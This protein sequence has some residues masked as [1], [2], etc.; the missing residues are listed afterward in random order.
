MSFESTDYVGQFARS[1]SG[2]RAEDRA[3]K[4]IDMGRVYVP[5]TKFTGD[6][7]QRT[8][9]GQFCAVMDTYGTRWTQSLKQLNARAE[10]LERAGIVP[11]ET[12]RAIRAL[13]IR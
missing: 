7:V 10:A 4:V 9:G 1:S 6:I 12:Q 13:T 5:A 3:P 8:V 11:D 2:T